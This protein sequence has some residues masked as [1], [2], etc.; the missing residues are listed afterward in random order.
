MPRTATALEQA[1]VDSAT[2]KGIRILVV[3][4]GVETSHPALK[5]SRIPTWQLTQTTSGGFSVVQEQGVDM[6]GH[7]TAVAWILHEF[8]PE[9]TVE[10]LRVLGGDLRTS[11]Q[12]VLAGLDWAISQKFGII[13][14]SFGTPNLQFLEGYKRVVDRAFTENVLVVSACNNFDFKK[15]ELPGFFP[16]VIS[17]D[18]GKLDALAIR[19][20]LGSMV[21]FVARGENHPGAL[22]GWPVR[23]RD[24]EQLRGASRGSDGRADPAAPARLERLRGQGRSLRDGAGLEAARGFAEGKADQGL[25]P[26]PPSPRMAARTLYCPPPGFRPPGDA[27]GKR[28][29]HPAG[30]DPEDPVSN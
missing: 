14:C 25:T 11:S 3:D 15:M 24:R 17:T 1:E 22:E 19:R 16:T 20:R 10:S 12:R 18:Y 7:G 5:G 4:S 8:A 2:G 6:F 27:V 9:A 29:L 30:T 23:D 13:N 28:Q 26:P 21:E